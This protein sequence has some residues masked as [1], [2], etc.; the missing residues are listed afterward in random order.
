MLK[1]FDWRGHRFA[2][3]AWVILDLH[4]TDHDPRLW[5]D[6][7]RFRPDRFRQRDDSPYDL[8]PQG[9]GDHHLNHRCPGEWATIEL[10]TRAVRLLTAA[11]TYAVS[12]Q[13]LTIDSA[14]M[15]AVPKSRFVIAGVRA[16]S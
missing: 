14:R 1:P 5:K 13:D 4:G 7:D 3:G 12:A 11:M 16:A 15:P 10:M 6:P 9:G 8:I 2:E